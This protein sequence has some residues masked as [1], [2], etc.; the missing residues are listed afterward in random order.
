MSKTVRHIEH[1]TRD[2]NVPHS[3]RASHS[4]KAVVSREL[5]RTNYSE[6]SDV[7]SDDDYASSSAARAISRLLD[8]IDF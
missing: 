4:R 6:I 2:E 7:L 8:D 5:N 1:I 3:F